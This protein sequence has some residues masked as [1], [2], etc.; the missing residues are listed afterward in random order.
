MEIINKGEEINLNK[1]MEKVKNSH[2]DG[3]SEELPWFHKMKL[4]VRSKLM[5]ML[6]K[7]ILLH[8]QRPL[9]SGWRLHVC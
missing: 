5:H 2:V 4:Q 6:F 9:T 8:E 7:H 3:E 1:W